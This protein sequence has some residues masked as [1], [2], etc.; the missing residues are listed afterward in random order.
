MIAKTLSANAYWTVNKHLARTIGIEETVVLAE[1][2]FMHSYFERRGALVDGEFYCSRETLKH[3]TGLSIDKLKSVVQSLVHHGVVQTRR[4][5]MPATT[6]WKIDFDAIEK[7]MTESETGI[8]SR[9]EALE[10]E[11]M[12]QSKGVGAENNSD[13]TEGKISQ[14]GGNSTNYATDNGKSANCHPVSGKSTN[15]LA[16]NPPTSW[17]ESHKQV[18]GKSP[19]IN[20]KLDNKL[21]NKLNNAPAMRISP[22]TLEKV[23]QRDAQLASVLE[24]YA[25]K[26]AALGITEQDAVAYINKLRY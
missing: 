5:G 12:S 3:I 25:D 16:E 24:R 10:V 11:I 6:H 17:W 1:L 14:D 18:R 19:N 2:I 9:L 7:L 13:A 20:N 21:N 22:E 4:A 26:F 15:K 8:E 23:R